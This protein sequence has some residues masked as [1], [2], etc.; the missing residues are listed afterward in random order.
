MSKPEN[1]FVKLGYQCNETASTYEVEDS[2]YW[3]DERVKASNS[4]QYYVYALAAEIVKKNQIKHIMDVGS[5][6]AVKTKK[7]LSPFVGRAILVDQP[8]CAP[9]VERFYPEAKFVESNLEVCDV[10][11]EDKIDLLICADVLEHLYNPL[12]CLEFS[13]EHIL[14]SGFAVFSTPE[15]DILRGKDCMI[16]PHPAHVREWNLDEFK[17][18]LEYVGFSVVEQLLMPAAKM[19]Y[20]EELAWKIIGASGLITKPIH[21]KSCQ[22]AICRK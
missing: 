6:P 13:F 4:Y 17:K 3:T 21:W 2:K 20:V 16:S 1:F 18:L 9:L 11:L 14:P 12:P 7:L 8:N 22:V 10:N 15:R 5:G 19:H